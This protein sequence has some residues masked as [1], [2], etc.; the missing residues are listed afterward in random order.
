MPLI[1]GGAGVLAHPRQYA[2]SRSHGIL[3]HLERHEPVI[4]GGLW[5]TENGA[6]L[7]ARWPGRSR[8][9]TSAIAWKFSQQVLACRGLR[10]DEGPA[11][12]LPLLWLT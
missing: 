5:I 9:D 8:C 4:L 10:L 11:P 3:Q 7:D 12:N 6:Q 2:L 1:K